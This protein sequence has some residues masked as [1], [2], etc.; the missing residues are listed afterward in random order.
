M[1][2]EPASLRCRLLYAGNIRFGLAELPQ[3]TQPL[4]LS[5]H[6]SRFV[7]SV[8]RSSNKSSRLLATLR[9]KTLDGGSRAKNAPAFRYAVDLFDTLRVVRRTLGGLLRDCL[10]A[11]DTRLLEDWDDCRSHRQDVQRSVSMWHVHQDFRKAAKREQRP[12]DRQVREKRRDFLGSRPPL[13][14]T[15]GAVRI[16]DTSIWTTPR[17][18]SVRTRLRHR[19]LDFLNRKNLRRPSLLAGKHRHEEQKGSPNIDT[20]L[21]FR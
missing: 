17:P 5:A 8:F 6:L 14:T 21:A 2:L 7:I 9:C 19:F 13:S 15:P 1:A 4:P 20:L 11:D 16:T 12:G 18:L 10:G 3:L